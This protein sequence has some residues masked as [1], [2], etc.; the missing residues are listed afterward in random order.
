MPN[1][2]CT[3][4]YCEVVD[5]LKSY[6]LLFL[7]GF[8]AFI[9]GVDVGT[10]GVK[11]VLKSLGP[12]VQVA[13]LDITNFS[14]AV[15]EGIP[16]GYHDCLPDELSEVNVFDQGKKWCNTAHVETIQSISTQY[17]RNVF[18]MPTLYSS[19][20]LEIRNAPRSINAKDVK[21]ALW[22]RGRSYWAISAYQMCD[23]NKCRRGTYGPCFRSLTA[24][25]T[26]CVQRGAE[27]ACLAGYTDC[28]I[29]AHSIVVV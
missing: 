23:A 14:K 16:F 13:G 1:Q 9:P 12:F 22:A 27:Q 15:P 18:A 11:F 19:Y 3:L 4:S 6:D 20:E 21:N 24:D 17:D 29:H 10:D 5:Q 2:N 26:D 28:M 25:Q 7:V 8:Q